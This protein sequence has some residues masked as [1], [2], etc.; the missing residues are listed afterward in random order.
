MDATNTGTG[1]RAAGLGVTRR[2]LLKLVGIAAGGAVLH[3]AMADLG[4]AAESTYT[5][6][7]KLEGK[8]KKG[9]SVIILG[10]GIAGML[11]AYELEKAGYLV[12][13]LEYRNKE[14][15]RCWTLRGGDTYTELGGA[16]Q[17]CEFDSGGYLNP[18]PWRIPYHHYGVM[19][20][21]R[22]LGVELEPF[23]ML[24]FNAYCHDPKAFGGAPQRIRHVMHDYQGG[25][26]E[27]LAKAI[28]QDDLDSSLSKED[29][30]KLL[31][32]LKSWGVLDKD[33]RYVK[34]R[35]TSIRRGYEVDPGGG[36]MPEAVFSQP[37]SFT[38][39][40]RSDLWKFISQHQLYEYQQALFE[41]KG[42]MDM[43]AK[44]FARKVGKH[45]RFNSRVSKIAQ[46]EKGV[47][48]TYTDLKSGKELQAK[49]DWCVCTLPL[50][51][52]SQLEVQASKEMKQAIDAVPYETGFK[53]GLQFKRRFWEEDDR[54]FG[55]VTFTASPLRNIS[56]PMPGLNRG[57]KGVLLG[58][59]MFGADSY[60]LSAMEPAERLKMVLHYGRQIH[61]QYD[62]E[63]DNGITVG[64][65]RVPWTNGCHGMWTE[66]SRAK[67]YKNLCQIDGRMILAGE[68]ASHIPAWIEGS[69]LSAMDAVERLHKRI[70]AG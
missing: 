53:A 63:F 66:D 68:H 46:G 9:T 14:G 37:L 24:N 16:S 23:T 35:E 30:E 6:P 41:P 31:E 2:D 18:G 55:G 59:Y 45:I 22:E 27:L 32:S 42:G 12:S 25:V 38:D 19:D 49:A 39:I 20:Y 47:T 4:F 52:L 62:K 7:M 57:G 64:W 10:A 58:A 61:P 56:Y 8:V 65:H 29:T 11:A 1:D 5:G 69:V 21:C 40:L 28:N 17:R 70:I 67:H 51:I 13:I 3:Q 54:I 36:L 43:I 34:S 15:G 60:K 50:S 26:A 33:Y 48:V 44:G